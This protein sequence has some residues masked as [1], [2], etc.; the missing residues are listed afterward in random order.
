MLNSAEPRLLGACCLRLE[1]A[2]EDLQSAVSSL[3]RGDMEAMERLESSILARDL[4]R[5]VSQIGALLESWASFVG[6]W[7]RLRGCYENGYAAGGAPSPTP[8]ERRSRAVL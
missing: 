6:G 8:V 5:Q 3:R 7:Q 1:Q 2:T 4:R